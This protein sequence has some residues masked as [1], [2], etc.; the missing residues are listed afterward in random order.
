MAE[1]TFSQVDETVCGYQNENFPIGDSNS[2]GRHL[3]GGVG[4]FGF[5]EGADDQCAYD[6]GY[7]PYGSPRQLYQKGINPVVLSPSSPYRL[8]RHAAN[9]RERKRM[10]SINTAFEELRCHVPTFPYEKRLSKIDTLRLAIAYIA[11]L[12]DI[13]LSGRD[14]L[15]FVETS[16]REGKKTSEEYTWNTSDLT[17]R[18]SWVKWESLGVKRRP[19]L[20]PYSGRQ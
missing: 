9:I 17:A 5:G 20:G 18:L 6:D 3:V 12:R 16:L 4:T 13:L 11:L 14:P 2:D 15:E 7:D 8:Q 19:Y 1:L 10:M